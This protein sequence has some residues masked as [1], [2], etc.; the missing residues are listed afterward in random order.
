MGWDE[1]GEDVFLN[2]EEQREEIKI[3]TIN[4]ETVSTFT[5]NKEYWEVHNEL[6]LKK[7]IF[8]I[9]KISDKDSITAGTIKYYILPIRYVGTRKN[10]VPT[11]LSLKRN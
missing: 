5:K 9:E 2:L 8:L 11:D 7:K 3:D 4:Y 1:K 6:S 10:I